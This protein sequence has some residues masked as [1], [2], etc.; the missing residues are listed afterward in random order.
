M[1]DT[2]SIIILKPTDTF[3]P[4]LTNIA[5]IQNELKN[6]LIEQ[7][8]V[9]T[10]ITSTDDIAYELYNRLNLT[11][12]VIGESCVIYEDINYIYQLFNHPMTPET[13]QPIN[14]IATVLARGL[15]F[16]DP[17]KSIYSDAII[18]KS[19]IKQSNYTCETADMNLELLVDVLSM[20]IKH[21][22]LF[23][24]TTGSMVEWVFS[25]NPM[26]KVD[27]D[28][29]DNFGCVGFKALDFEFICYFQKQFYPESIDNE[30]NQKATLLLGT[31]LVYGDVIICHVSDN[32]FSDINANTLNKILLYLTSGASSREGDVVR[33]NLGNDIEAASKEKIDGLYVVK[34]K[35]INLANKLKNFQVIC[36]GLNCNEKINKSIYCCK[37]CNIAQ[38]HSIECRDSNITHHKKLCPI[39]K[40][41]NAINTEQN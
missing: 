27:E 19:K 8:V 25:S 39:D 6:Y 10:V 35:Y 18:V 9:E 38:Y 14:S 24:E 1:T 37:H 15:H 3:K 4:K 26:E 17:S 11:H 30:L 32:N 31:H 40:I 22:G 16:K 41:Q 29:Q 34:N 20:K 21:V 28:M 5:N 33:D 23:I 2:F 13:T 7:N 36:H 12:D